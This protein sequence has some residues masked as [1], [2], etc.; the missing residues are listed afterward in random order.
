MV[1]G[2]EDGRAVSASA[3]LDAAGDARTATSRAGTS[4]LTERGSDGSSPRG[5]QGPAVGSLGRS[6]PRADA[7]LMAA[8]PAP[9]VS[10]A[11]LLTWRVIA[12]IVVL[13]GV[14]G[15]AAAVVVRAGPA[16][17]VALDGNEVVVK[18]GDKIVE[19]TPLQVS[20]LPRRYQDEL[21]RGKRV[22]DRADA[23]E[24][25]A[26]ITRLALQEGTLQP[27]AGI[28]VTTTSPPTT[29]GPAPP[30]AGQNGGAN[31]SVVGP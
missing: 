17:A 23:D 25:I 21:G 18:E 26:G 24:Y 4:L 28:V 16:W 31:T 1:D 29:P 20:Q 11:R 19:R 6:S 15:A 27:G 14:L 30:P 13:L 12:F 5:P 9:A 10:R 8:V 2:G 22:E 3:A 7:S